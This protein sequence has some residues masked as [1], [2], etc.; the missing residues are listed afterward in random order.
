MSREE[1]QSLKRK[2]NFRSIIC[3]KR[4]CF[5]PQYVDSHTCPPVPVPCSFVFRL[6][7]A[8]SNENLET[9]CMTVPRGIVQQYI[10]PRSHKY[11]QAREAYLGALGLGLRLQVRNLCKKNAVS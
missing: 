1:S 3:A 8:C 11:A 5:E 10:L 6:S 7:R 2:K 4:L 9:S